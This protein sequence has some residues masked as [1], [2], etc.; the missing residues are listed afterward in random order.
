[1]RYLEK[2][3]IS[4]LQLKSLLNPLLGKKKAR[5]AVYAPKSRSNAAWIK[6]ELEIVLAL[7]R[8]LKHIRLLQLFHCT[9]DPYQKV[10]LYNNR[11][12]YKVVK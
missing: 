7:S 5:R 9:L 3:E 4:Q 8:D 2:I 10:I 11:Q 6:V 12:E 1:M